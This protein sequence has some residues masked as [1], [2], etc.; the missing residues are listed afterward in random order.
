MPCRTSPPAALPSPRG[1]CP[2]ARPGRR[3][4]CPATAARTA[5]STAASSTTPVSDRSGAG[6]Q[7]GED[8]A[9]RSH[10]DLAVAAPGPDVDL[11]GVTLGRRGPTDRA[12]QVV[13][14]G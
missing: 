3:T 12:G 5:T 7:L 9:G 2:R 6:R 8:R 13:E 10:G 14:R 4:P 1:S 11:L